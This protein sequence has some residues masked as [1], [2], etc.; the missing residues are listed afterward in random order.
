MTTEKQN[1]ANRQNSLL[2]GVKTDE[3]KEISRLNALKHGFFSQII[4]SEDKISSKEFCEEIY[5]YFTPEN[6]YEAQLVEIILSNL[7]TY[8]RISILESKLISSEIEKTLH[9]TQDFTTEA[10]DTE[11]QRNFRNNIMDELF[12][13]QRYKTVCIN[14]I[15]KTQHELERL[16][17][18]RNGE[19]V[20]APLAA[21]MLISIK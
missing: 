5:A 19:H 20:P 14:L 15:N 9:A 7:L 21:D 6:T 17:R 8:R 12:K 1:E 18:I 10:F 13:F 2:G 3:G 11:Y 16:I 4:I